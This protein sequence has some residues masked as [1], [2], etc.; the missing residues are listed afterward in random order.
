M[1]K[2]RL[3]DYPSRFGW[4]KLLRI[5]K[6]T[7]F[8]ILA[9]MFDVSALVYSQ[10]SK[11]SIYVKDGSLN[12]I[13]REIEKL[14]EYRFFYQNEQIS[15]V[16]RKSIDVTDKN[17]LD[18]LSDLL[19]ETGLSYKLVER[20][21]I[22]FP[23]SEYNEGYVKR[24]S[25]EYYETQQFR[26]ITGKVTDSSGL[27]L[28][29]VTIAVKGTTI[30][31]VSNADG[32]YSLSVTSSD[33]VLLFSFV[34]MKSQEIS[35]AG[36]STI[37]VTMEADAI[38]IDEVVAIGYGSQKKVNLTGAVSTV[39]G[40]ALVAVSTPNLSNTLAGRMGGVTVQQ[41]NG[42]PGSSS[43]IQIRGQDPLYV[44]DGIIKSKREFDALDANSVENIS[45]LKDA[46]SAAVYGAKASGGVVLVNTKI[47]TSGAPTITFKAAT[48]TEKRTFK[49]D[50]ASAYDHAIMW[51]DYNT[52]IGTP[53]GQATYYA[54]DELD[55]F[56]NYPGKYPSWLEYTWND[57]VSH[58]Y[59][60]SVS[61]GSE[62]TKYYI[63]A[64]YY[65]GTGFMKNITSTKQDFRINI[66]S[67]IA[68]NLTSE[69]RFNYVSGLNSAPMWAN[70]NGAFDL[71]NL[72]NG[73]I[74]S[75]RTR[76]PYVNGLASDQRG[77]HPLEAAKQGYIDDTEDDFNAIIGLKYEVPFIKGLN[78][79][80][81]Y[82]QH[83]SYLDGKTFNEFYTFYTFPKSG[84]HSNLIA[85]DAEPT[86]TRVYAQ[87]PYEYVR[88]SSNRG[89]DYQLNAMIEYDNS[90]G[91]HNFNGILVYEQTESSNSSMTGTG[92]DLFSSSL[93][94]L[95]AASSEPERRTVTGTA[96]ESG[97]LSYI[98]RLSYNYAG[99]YLFETSFRKDG[100]VNFPKEKRWGFFPSVSLG[101]RVSDENWFKNRVGFVDNL[102][103]RGSIGVLGNDNVG[104]FQYLD[105]Y[106]LSGSVYYGKVYQGVQTTGIPN[107]NITWEKSTTYN[108]G[109]DFYFLESFSFTG[110]VFYK[111][112]TDILETRGAVVPGTFGGSMPDENW[113]VSNDKGFELMLGYQG[114]VTKD[115]KYFIR[116]NLGYSIDEVEKTF[117]PEN[118]PDY[119][120][121]IGKPRNRIL[122]YRTEGILRTQDAYDE[123]LTRVSTF[124]GAVPELGW[125]AMQDLR[126]PVE[127]NVPDGKVD[128]YDRDILSYNAVPRLNY[129]I[130]I[131][132]DWKQFKLTALFQGI[133][134]WDRMLSGSSF[135]HTNPNVAPAMKI[136]YW[137]YENID[138][139]LPRMSKNR[140]HYTQ[141]SDFW[142]RDAS[143]VRLKELSLYYSV[144][145]L[146]T[147]RIKA[148]DV[149][150]SFTGTNLFTW[151]KMTEF[152]PEQ[153][154]LHSYPMMKSFTFRLSVTY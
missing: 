92:E 127:E 8:L 88:Q 57:P 72:V 20:N 36:Q 51:N 24:Q 151:S 29:G 103:L 38:G 97:R 28:P 126:G 80:I 121:P 64:G 1:K 81:R 153:R 23:M 34:G 65:D 147:S 52:L 116:G 99:K 22:I 73:L 110:E 18:L 33:A 49:L 154:L 74:T 142:L 105:E 104:N 135:L 100:S 145:E 9:L 11:I 90:F 82:S 120:N 141:A 13:F 84:S 47:G 59:N 41:A 31:T 107:Y 122:G 5:M 71:N 70:D 17:V 143:F 63:S 25:W 21:I 19:G 37:N 69:I 10:N 55:E 112:T 2:K 30:G 87:K 35:V 144:P 14:S 150:L 60:L 6:L 137:T 146:I 115:L 12:E 54:Q 96:S 140:N 27:P 77:W 117:V 98:G 148:K 46:A 75:K 44:I 132:G 26:A 3:P 39:V 32:E 102:K 67:I 129:G 139:E 133:G 78:L 134:K 123:Y 85:D 53:A 130:N 91:K 58:Q 118:Q 43:S 136:D 109:L 16:E 83:R 62:K 93:P 86:T 15:N 42:R 66:E 114:D 7:I 119:L 4:A 113:G 106:S 89:K 111:K 125:L 124:R 40:E 61:G 76:R 50:Y 95:F 56:Q 79:N 131:G 68:K 48:S 128:S 108:I 101:W 94:Y 152:D 149:L 45:I 138:A